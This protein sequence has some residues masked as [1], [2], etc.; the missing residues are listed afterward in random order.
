MSHRA[1]IIG[2][3]RMGAGRDHIS[4]WVY[5]HI[6]AYLALAA[7]VEVVGFVDRVQARAEWAAKKWDVAYAGDHAKAALDEL[8]PD[9]VSICTP[10]SDRDEFF[11]ILTGHYLKGVWCEKPAMSKYGCLLG[12]HNK[13]IPVQVNYIRRFDPRHQEIASRR[14]QHL[15]EMVLTYDGAVLIWFGALDMH[16]VAHVT[17]LAAFWRIK[18]ITYIPFHG[19]SLYILR[20]PGPGAGRYLNWHDQIFVGGGVVDGFMERGLENLLNHIDTEGATPLLSG[21]TTE[22]PLIEAQAQAIVDGDYYGSHEDCG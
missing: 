21:L 6:E 12:A 3:G 15:E 11:R 1:L 10:P 9:I 7:R 17:D 18:T 22:T 20:E 5:T 8:K 14:A 4:P 2:C 13:E 16:T 19:P